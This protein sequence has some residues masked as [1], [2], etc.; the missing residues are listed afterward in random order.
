VVFIDGSLRR[1]RVV[2]T[3][4][5][6]SS[7]VLP[8][9]RALKAQIRVRENIL[10]EIEAIRRRLSLLWLLRRQ[11][12]PKAVQSTSRGSHRRKWMAKDRRKTG[13]RKLA[14]AGKVS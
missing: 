4:L 9:V 6:P 14:R 3:H 13:P 10:N 1:I 2:S 11:G 7:A 8:N 12:L 5:T